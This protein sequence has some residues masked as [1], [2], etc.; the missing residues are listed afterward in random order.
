MFKKVLIAFLVSVQVAG[1][2]AAYSIDDGQFYFRYKVGA[3]TSE[4][5]PD[6]QTKD[7]TAYYIGGVGRAF[8]EKLP[9]KPQW[10]DDNWKITKGS[11]PTGLSFNPSTR[12]FEGAPED[13]TSD[14][15]VELN[16]YDSSGAKVASAVA[17]FSIY[18]L[19]DQTVDVDIYNHTGK[20]GS[21]AL[22]LPDGVV[23]DGDP[24]LLSPVAP[25]VTFNARYFDGTPT[26]AG[27]YPVLA[28]GYNFLGKATVAFI[29]R[30]SVEDAPTFN[31]IA[32]DL[33]PLHQIQYYGCYQANECRVWDQQG[34]PKIKSAIKDASK[35]RYLVEVQDGG[36]LPGSL[37][38]Y[39]G[40]YNLKM[41]GTTYQAFDQATIRYKAI[42]T[43]GTVGYSNWFKI[44]SLGL[45]AVCQP[46]QGFTSVNLLG[47]VGLDFNGGGYSIPTGRD[48]NVK[49]FTITG[50]ALPPGLTLNA[51]TGLISGKPTKLEDTKGLAIRID[52]PSVPGAQ[53][54]ICGPYDFQ[55]AP[56]RTSLDIRNLKAHYRVGDP[57]D[58]E[59]KPI[60][61]IIEP[62]KVTMS[63]G[64]AL[65]PG[66]QYDEITRHLSGTVDQAGNF[67]AQFV[68]ENGD[69]I[70]Y[71]RPIAFAGHE[72]LHINDVASTITIKQY[73]SSAQILPISYDNKTPIAPG[74]ETFALVGGPLPDGIVFNPYQLM[75]SG[76]TRLPVNKYGPFKIKLTD[77][78]G[79][80]DET[81]DF[82]IDV[83]QRDDLVANGTVDPLTFTVNFKDPGQQAF[84]V[85]QPPL[86]QGYLPLTYELTPATLP[87]GLV[88]DTATGLISGKPLVKSETAGY[89][90][91]VREQGPDNLSKTS[92]PFKIV[93]A[94]P[95]PFPADQ[96]LAK[97]EGNA[98][99]PAINSVSPTPLLTQ[100][101]QYLV[102]S[103]TAVQ[104]DN[105][106][107]N[108][109]GL[110]FDTSTGILSGQPSQEFDGLVSLNFHDGGARQAKLQVPV[111]I[112][113]YPALTSAK[114]VYDLPRLSQAADFDVRVVPAN[115]GF[116][117]GADYSLAPTSDK[118]PSGLSLSGGA[119]V[120]STSVAK[121]AVYKLII[122]AVSKANG[123]IVDYPLTL[124]IANEEPMKLDM[125]PNDKLVFM[126]DES[127]HV[128]VPPRGWFTNPKATG[129]YVAPVTWSLQDQPSWMTIG[130]DGQIYGNPSGLGEWTVKVV[131]TDKENHRAEDT[132]IVKVTLSGNPKLSELNGKAPG[133]EVLRV[134]NGETFK[135]SAKLV[136]NAVSPWQWVAS[137]KPDTL[138]ID[139][140]TGVLTG[141]INANGTTNWNMGVKDADDRTSQQQFA[142]SVVT[143]PPLS[144]APA[145]AAKNGKQYD[146]AQPIDVQF[147][148]ATN[149]V[150]TVDY[151]ISGDLPGP[152]FYKFYEG[153]TPAGLASYV[154]EDGQ[155][156][157]EIIHQPAGSTVEQTENSLLPPD[158]MIFDT[159]SLRLQGIAS[160]TGSFTFSLV[161]S[162]D[163]QATGYKVNPNDP[164][165]S[166]YNVAQSSPVTVSVGPATDLQIANSA[167]SEAL[168]QFTSAPKLVTTVTNA[169][170]GRGMSW[171]ALAGALPTGI[172]KS[173][174]GT[175]LR[176]AGYASVQGT[177]DN[178]VWEGTDLAGRK[179]V[180]SPVS[181][182]VGPRQSLALVAAP[183]TPRPMIV[184]DQ[185]ADLKVT[186]ANVADGKLI[187]TANWTVSGASKLPPDVTYDIADDGVH[188]HGTSDK[189]ALYS[190]ITVSA[191]DS[192]NATA[193]IN[194]VFNVIANPAPI[195]LN[196]AN[197][198][199]KPGFPIEMQPPFA[200]AALSTDNTYGDVRF[201]SN[202]LPNIPGITL[203]GTTGFLTG[204]L[205]QP[206]TVTFDLFVTDD[207]NRVTSKPVTAEIIPYLRLIAP[208]TINVEQGA[209]TN[210]PIATDYVIG[211][212]TYAKGA[213]N[214]PD[215]LTVDLTT[216]SV[217]GRPSAATGDYPGLTIVG[218]DTFGVHQ[219]VRSSNPFTIHVDPI[220]ASP[221][222]SAIP[223]NRMVFGT[224]G[225]AVTPFTPTVRDNLAGR[226]W[227]YAGT[228]Y[229]LNRTLP[230]GLLFDTQT[231]T[232]S[233]TPSEP[234]IIRD[235]K[236]KVTAENGDSSETPAFWF[237]VAPKDPIVP[238][239]GQK[240][241]YSVYVGSTFTSDKP[242]FDNV[243]G[244][245][246]Y[247]MVESAGLG[248][249]DTTTG[250]F[251]HPA[252]LATDIGTWPITVIVT[253]EFGRTGT[254]A[255]IKAVKPL[256]T[257]TLR[258]TV[259]G[260]TAPHVC[261][262]YIQ[263]FVGAVDVF[264][265]AAL[266]ASPFGYGTDPDNLKDPSVVQGGNGKDG[267]LLCWNDVN[268]AWLDITVPGSGTLPSGEIKLY[269]RDDVWGSSAIFTD[270]GLSRKNEDGSFTPLV[271]KAIPDARPAQIVTL[272][273]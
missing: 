119:I 175:I 166:E 149:S 27:T 208:T 47:Y 197:I 143:V 55:I 215:G 64:A 194:L 34:T 262:G 111:K 147:Q 138:D 200:S 60:G 46:S 145:T 66:V 206:T 163:H 127:T 238:T 260:S 105:S 169:A 107:P 188:F 177:F 239:P 121:G 264:P 130:T 129:S 4:E 20:Y 79:Q 123:I 187:G 88:F 94:D 154:H 135:T 102:G 203:D 168:S 131:A 68:Y 153:G 116:Y 157:M 97:L 256:P 184:F 261:M 220:N 182:T 122:R 23:I 174:D 191:K 29:G 234:V 189:I 42:D 39:D 3:E 211:K 186:A 18:E 179:I 126:I 89:Q 11:L 247:A 214:W 61:A 199:T 115:T 87:D 12:T 106:E 242:L 246:T 240:T 14:T 159:L 26:K 134:R 92:E 101:A 172:T 45:S 228:V 56:D 219:D 216:G 160:R 103:E 142:Y 100:F 95:P 202:D 227:N 57:I 113:P 144:L 70:K 30:Y 67:Q 218:T 69:G 152:L 266:T 171:R 263:L 76:G 248:A 205:N 117:K 21:Y 93:V 33:E 167:D 267:G 72:A 50:G 259:Y 265:G 38:F 252:Y 198:K 161:A 222:I 192:R 75:V 32:D 120:G 204:T 5:N 213:G 8:S 78:S 270:V 180:S 217:S 243:I 36:K 245:L 156:G 35:V 210:E 136:S 241:S 24:K 255:L 43:D 110:T 2:A 209:V 178:I 258:L 232:I 170:Y 10:E 272:Q 193:S 133:T 212:V 83:T 82:Y 226:P 146:A 268:V 16:G 112:H 236:I 91:T 235:L 77:S 15:S 96:T 150:G 31:Q 41:S 19:P 6:S 51:T 196:V 181:F 53:P 221:V 139:A 84:S 118:L 183:K 71:Q 17:H 74:S 49:T 59:L 54:T 224:Q 151:A 141:R 137:G 48:T 62:I 230:A 22:K 9:M 44:G 249:F 109:A 185:D 40:P 7:I 237:G 25:G 250:V 65:P 223:G 254:L 253:D 162:D 132:V 176:Y 271:R 104:F 244:N 195:V 1:P 98:D 251:T 52:Y 63:A 269:Q 73:D 233:G 108:V 90:L 257:S 28:L 173:D 80:F 128:V 81:K 201:Y 86:A 164:T 85:K 37:Q 225:T 207:T 99:G 273:F 125:Q 124:K 148:A 158:H 165:H 190:G 229:S 114:T 13:V 58:A 231:G 155:G 140:P